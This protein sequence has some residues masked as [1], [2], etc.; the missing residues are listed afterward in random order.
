MYL[1]R[2]S[3]QGQGSWGRKPR[4]RSSFF[5]KIPEN[6]SYPRF[7]TGAGELGPQAAFAKCEKCI[8]SAILD[9]GRGVGVVGTVGEANRLTPS[10][11]EDVSKKIQIL[12]I[13]AHI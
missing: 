6:V 12:V 1:I 4:L 8:L 5:G 11:L 13:V 7:W 10:T 9:R 3:R 2:D